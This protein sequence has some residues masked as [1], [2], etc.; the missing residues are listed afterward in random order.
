MKMDIATPKNENREE[1]VPAYRRCREGNGKGH[2]AAPLSPFPSFEEGRDDVLNCEMVTDRH[3]DWLLTAPF[4]VLYRQLCLVGSVDNPN[5]TS[6]HLLVTR[7]NT[8]W[9]Y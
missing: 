1:N 2:E 3:C 6:L 5:Q 9:H 4:K 7:Q 8:V